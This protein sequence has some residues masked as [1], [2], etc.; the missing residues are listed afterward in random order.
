[1]A[2]QIDDNMLGDY[3]YVTF[4]LRLTLDRNGRLIRGDLVD[5][6]SDKGTRF[7]DV[8][9]MTQALAARLNSSDQT[10]AGAES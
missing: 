5:T 1:M 4:I 10:E 6:A 9:D 3:Q 8:L 2:T 7:N